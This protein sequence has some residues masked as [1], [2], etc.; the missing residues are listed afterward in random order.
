[1]RVGQ[2]IYGCKISSS[3]DSSYCIE[4]ANSLFC[5]ESQKSGFNLVKNDIAAK[6][7]IELII[8][9][10][11]SAGEYQQWIAELPATIPLEWIGLESEV[12]D[13][14]REREAESASTR[15]SKLL[16]DELLNWQ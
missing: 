12:S 15:A 7:N 5:E 6:S 16:Q 2:I 9:D 1:F 13:E 3:A 8:P 4:L 10:A 14:A 11:T